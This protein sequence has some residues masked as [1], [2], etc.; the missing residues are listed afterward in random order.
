MSS[1][2]TPVIFCNACGAHNAPDARFCQS[3]GQAMGTVQPVPIT[4]SVAL[5]AAHPYGGFW[6]RVLAWLI[7]VILVGI[8][9]MPIRVAMGVGMGLGRFG[10]TPPDPGMLLAHMGALFT[11][12]GLNTVV[13]WLYDAAMTSSTKQGTVGKIAVGLK[14]TT[15]T[16][17]RLS[18]AHA[19]GRHFAKY[20]SAIILGIGYLMVAFTERKQG[21][22]DI[23]AGTLVQKTR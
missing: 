17:Q 2:G 11:F 10:S 23:I 12:M 19:T 15:L 22:H 13:N 3:C 14:V 16:G 5:Y 9:M 20:V 7:D 8:V 4:S 18:F 6:I 1:T 21:L